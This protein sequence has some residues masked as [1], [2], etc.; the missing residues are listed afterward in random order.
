MTTTQIFLSGLMLRRVVTYLISGRSR[1]RWRS[2]ISIFVYPKRRGGRVDARWRIG[3]QNRLHVQALLKQITTSARSI[4]RI[5]LHRCRQKYRPAA[6]QAC[7][8]KPGRP[9]PRTVRK[10]EPSEHYVPQYSPPQRTDRRR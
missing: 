9:Y 6:L 8:G 3:M 2:V 7:L 4:V 5:D 1:A 10:T